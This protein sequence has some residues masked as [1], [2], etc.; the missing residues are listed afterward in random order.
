MTEPS[1]TESPNA[2]APSTS[3]PTITIEQEPVDS[4]DAR[5]ALDQYAR[6]LDELFP[7]G[8]DAAKAA[9]PA[10]G[11]LTPPHGV[12]LLV[13]SDREVA[14]CG[15]L[16]V[17]AASARSEAFAE[18][19][20]MW[21]SRALRG[22]GVGRR[23]LEELEGHAS[24]LGCHRVRLDTAAELH[25]ARAL[26]VRAGYAEIPDYNGNPYARHWFEKVLG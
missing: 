21:V 7:T 8:F 15:A 17:H 24:G 16:R 20:R 6:E 1:S 5:W 11:D 22:G 18:V 19:K 13:R 10:P 26:Y 23:L 4:A 2:S 14:G 9:A 25:A 12:F 3:T